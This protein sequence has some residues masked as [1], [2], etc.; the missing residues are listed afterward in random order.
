MEGLSTLLSVLIAVVGLV[1]IVFIIAKY[2]YQVKKAMIEKGLAMPQEATRIKY[3]DMGCVLGG[4]GVGLL[5][6]SFYTGLS[7]SE[8]TIDLLAWGTICL[9]TGAGL[10]LAQRLRNKQD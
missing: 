7:L 9:A 6:S 3:I 4:L 8:D 2:S 10:V 5:I 1:V